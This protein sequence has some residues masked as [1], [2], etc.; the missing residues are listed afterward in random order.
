[1]NKDDILG[2]MV[3]SKSGRDI[4]RRFL[5][6]KVIDKE[7]VYISDGDLRKVEKPK[8]KKLKHL[9]LTCVIAEEIKKLLLNGDK[10][11]NSKIR[12]FLRSEDTNKEV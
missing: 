4:N 5:V 3:I 1:M 8:K 11:S 12:S 10:V 7:Y 6:M 9:C 2:F